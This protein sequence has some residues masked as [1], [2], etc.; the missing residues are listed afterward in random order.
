MVPALR[1]VH[2]NALAGGAIVG[3]VGR[4]AARLGS[5]VLAAMVAVSLLTWL[6]LYR[7]YRVSRVEAVLLLLAYL[8]T[9][10]LIG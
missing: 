1:R 8:L 4:G 6:V 7:R 3:L 2:L 5:P 9:L 10:P